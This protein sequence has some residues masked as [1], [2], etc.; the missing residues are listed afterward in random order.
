MK[1]QIMI[2]IEESTH[3]K[4]K[5]ISKEIFGRVNFSKWIELKAEEDYLKKTK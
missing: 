1:K 3:Q 2:R 4:A 5:E